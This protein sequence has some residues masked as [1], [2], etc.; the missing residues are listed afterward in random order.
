MIA[1][2]A[3]RTKMLQLAFMV[4]KAAVSKKLIPTRLQGHPY[5]LPHRRLAQLTAASRSLPVV[6]IAGGAKLQL[7][8]AGHCTFPGTIFLEIRF[9]DFG[10]PW[11]GLPAPGAFSGY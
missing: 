7:V 6:R 11:R 2:S 10:T 3:S 4:A 9:G 8:G 1:S 5:G